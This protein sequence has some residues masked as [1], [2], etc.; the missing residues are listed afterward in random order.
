MK[1]NIKF[2]LFFL[3]TVFQVPVFG[4]SVNLPFGHQSYHWMD[5]FEI[6]SGE[7]A[8]FHTSHKQYTR[9]DV[10]QLALNYLKDVDPTDL[11]DQDYRDLKFLFRDNN[12]QLDSV[13]HLSVNHEEFVK[14]EQ[15]FLKYFLKTPANFLE[16]SNADFNIVI[17]PIVSVDV[18]VENTESG[19]SGYLQRTQGLEMRGSIGDKV[20]YYSDIL[21]YFDRFP[22]HVRRYTN[23]HEAI[24]GLGWYTGPY[25]TG[26][27]DSLHDAINA[28]AFIDFKP[29]KQI[30]VQLGHGNNFIGNGYRSLMLSN[31]SQNYFYLKANTKIW[32]FD[33]QNIFA[34]MRQI[35]TRRTFSSASNLAK[36]YLAAHHLS[37]NVGKNLNLGVYEGVVFHRPNDG[38][39]DLNY[40][41]PLILYRSVERNLDSPDNMI[42]G[43]DFKW[44]LANRFSLYGQVVLDELQLSNLFSNPDSWA[45]KFGLQLGL[46]YIDVFGVDH[47]DLQ[48]EYNAVRPYTYQ[49]YDTLVTYTHASQPLAHPQG[50]NFSEFLAILRYQ[51]STKL[52]FEGRVMFSNVGKDTSGVNWGSNIFLNYDT[53]PIDDGLTIGQ[54]V[55][56][57]IV[58]FNLSA[59]YMLFHNCFVDVNLMLRSENS[60]I[61]AY[62]YNALMFTTGIRWNFWKQRFDF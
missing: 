7:L 56:T 53:R 10:A 36:K 33:Y 41:N 23:E 35:T 42:I 61:D 21:L 30:K 25:S 54:G 13:A 28:N 34:E 9:F 27:I 60:V 37:L 39:F 62:D 48:V 32:K 24:P 1:K 59:S 38:G 52:F 16:F 26:S 15:P 8:D 45:H 5:R 29:I 49:H 55:N 20:G 19:N 3:L 50:A 17:Q 6:K 57:N 11:T 44:N 58:L 46:K 47:L 12:Y 2:F 43:G 4:Q 31:Y 51:P 18:G 22:A 40:I 14:R